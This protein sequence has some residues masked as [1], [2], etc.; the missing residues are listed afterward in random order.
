MS[1]DFQFP[2]PASE[3]TP[4]PLPKQRS[5][6]VLPWMVAGLAVLALGVVSIY[7]KKLIDEQ[8]ARAYQAMR[9]A[10]EYGSRPGSR[11][12]GRMPG[13]RP[14]APPRSPTSCVRPTPGSVSR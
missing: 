7:A 13:G 4:A 8:T 11:P 9:M 10:D 2:E 3:A 12:I 6:V 5:P 14:S 1:D